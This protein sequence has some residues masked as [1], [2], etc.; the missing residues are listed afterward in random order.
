[1]VANPAEMD[2]ML[3]FDPT[4]S[5]EEQ[6]FCHKNAIMRDLHLIADECQ[7]IYLLRGWEASRGARAEHSLA[8]YLQIE[9][10]SQ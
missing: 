4:K 5:M 3:G 6:G 7:A 8:E 1:M 9:I 2:T 10:Y